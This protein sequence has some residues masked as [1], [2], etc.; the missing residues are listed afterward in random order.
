MHSGVGVSLRQTSSRFLVLPS[1]ERETVLQG[2]PVVS[3]VAIG[4]AP[5]FAIA[6]AMLGYGTLA[7]A[8][9][10]VVVASAVVASALSFDR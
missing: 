2:V 7:I 6:G 9:S 1:T 3:G 4:V 8:F 5:A 10:G